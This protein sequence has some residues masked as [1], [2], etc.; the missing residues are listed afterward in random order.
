MKKI[1]CLLTI[2]II[3]MACSNPEQNTATGNSVDSL[4]PGDSIATDKTSGP[5]VDNSGGTNAT[6]TFTD[7]SAKNHSV[8]STHER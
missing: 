1:I 3:F 7:S 2:V 8:D 4:H 5:G 6:G